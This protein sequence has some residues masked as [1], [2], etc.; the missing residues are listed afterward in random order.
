MNRTDLRARLAREIDSWG[1][2]EGA[3]HRHEHHQHH[4]HSPRMRRH[5]SRH[6]LD[7]EDHGPNLRPVLYG[8]LALAAL[9]IGKRE[10][11]QLKRYLKIERM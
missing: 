11:P 2:E 7:G 6:G 9:A 1:H 3:T 5:E 10:I 4:H 8:A